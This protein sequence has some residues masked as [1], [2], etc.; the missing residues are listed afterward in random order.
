MFSQIFLLSLVYGHG[1]LTSPAAISETVDKITADRPCGRDGEAIGL[2]ATAKLTRRSGAETKANKRNRN[3][4][5]TQADKAKTGKAAEPATGEAA[6]PATG[7]A[8]KP[9]TEGAAVPK[10][11]KAAKTDTGKAASNVTLA[12]KGATGAGG[13]APSSNTLS[14][15]Q[16]VE[17][18]WLIRNPDGSGP[19]TVELDLEGGTKFLTPLK[20][21]TQVPGNNGDGAKAGIPYQFT[22]QIPAG[23]NCKNC[24]LRVKQPNDFGSCAF[25]N[26]A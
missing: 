15:G 8:A 10:T 1:R 5:S 17:M 2:T 22:V 16:V 23:T 14:A 9:E 21:Q 7:E 18:T 13:T 11:D 24:L 12:E 4:K 25:V 26:I 6:E 3:P 20:V 19:V